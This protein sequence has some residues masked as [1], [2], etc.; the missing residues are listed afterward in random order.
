MYGSD[1]IDSIL[2]ILFCF[3]KDEMAIVA[4][5]E[6]AFYRF[7]V[8]EDHRNNLRVFFFGGGVGKKTATQMTS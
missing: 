6:Q 3:R 5:I 8:D 1:M 7:R 2:G 4:D